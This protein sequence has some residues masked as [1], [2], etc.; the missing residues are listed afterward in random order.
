MKWTSSRT[1]TNIKRP[2]RIQRWV[3]VLK[4][5]LLESLSKIKENGKVKVVGDRKTDNTNFET[6]KYT[7]L[8]IYSYS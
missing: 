1:L 4:Y 8:Y 5:N 7:D 6:F 3:L 2:I